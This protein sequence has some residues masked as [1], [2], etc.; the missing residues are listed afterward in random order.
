M[1]R[2]IRITSNVLVVLSFTKICTIFGTKKC[3]DTKKAESVQ[4]TKSLYANSVWKRSQ[5]EIKI[6]TQL[7]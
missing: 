3:D 7:M 6:F 1:K 2:K 4:F 5:I